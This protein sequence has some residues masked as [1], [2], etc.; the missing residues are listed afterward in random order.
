MT[1]DRKFALGGDCGERAFKSTIESA[2]QKNIGKL[3]QLRDNSY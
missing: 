1:K 2:I 3:D